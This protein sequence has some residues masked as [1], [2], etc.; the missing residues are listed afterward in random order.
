M[1][2]SHRLFLRKWY[3]SYINVHISG[4]SRRMPFV[5]MFTHLCR[6]QAG[7]L[8]KRHLC[9]CRGDARAGLPARV[10][11]SVDLQLHTRAACTSEFGL[12]SGQK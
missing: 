9:G 1:I 2:P 7:F 6:R 5:P 10:L 11:H 8:L 4:A 12:E 3:C